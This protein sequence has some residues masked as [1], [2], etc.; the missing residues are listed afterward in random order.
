[1]DRE[2]R[3]RQLEPHNLLALSAYSVLLRFACPA[4]ATDSQVARR[5]ANTVRTSSL[6]IG[7]MM[8]VRVSASSVWCCTFFADRLWGSPRSVT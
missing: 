7:M 3:I 2:S 5:P 4:M 6:Q 8:A 1:M